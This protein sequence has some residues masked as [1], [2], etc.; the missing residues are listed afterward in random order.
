MPV[1]RLW[2]QQQASKV[3]LFL[4]SLFDFHQLGT[5]MIS[6]DHEMTY[7]VKTTQPLGPTKGSPAG[8]LQYWQVSAASLSGPRIRASLSGMGIDWMQMSEDGF[9]R[10]H[11][12][13][14]FVTDDVRSS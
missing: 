8:T 6:L 4:V 14:Q 9:W 12:R 7:L 13:A 10:P 5:D 2:E 3:N 1:G 11:V